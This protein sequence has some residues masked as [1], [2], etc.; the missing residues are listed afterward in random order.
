M[1]ATVTQTRPQFVNYENKMKEKKLFGVSSKNVTIA[2]GEMMSLKKT[3]G[4]KQMLD[5][6]VRMQEE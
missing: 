4:T 6:E 1:F 5:N 2:Q 3:N